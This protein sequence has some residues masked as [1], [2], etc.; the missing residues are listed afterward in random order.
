MNI[1]LKH[2]AHF[3]NQ[4]TNDEQAGN[5]TSFMPWLLHGLDFLNQ[6]YNVKQII[7][8]FDEL[9]FSN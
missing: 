4:V 8:S 2:W 7:K 5:L 3:Y 9:R 6:T 1:D